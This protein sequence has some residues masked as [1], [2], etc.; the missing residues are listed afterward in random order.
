[1]GNSEIYIS[2][3][4]AHDETYTAGNVSMLETMSVVE[5]TTYIWPILSIAKPKVPLYYVSIVGRAWQYY[6]ETYIF[7]QSYG[8]VT[9]EKLYS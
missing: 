1:M 5:T 6:K 7:C 2:K 8:T 4:S 3:Y 9:W